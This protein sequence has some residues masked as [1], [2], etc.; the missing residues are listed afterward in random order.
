MERTE[1]LARDDG[2][3]PPMAFRFVVTRAPALQLIRK[4][5]S[6]SLYRMNEREGCTSCTT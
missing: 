4:A 1:D 2:N 6:Y 5:S 3:L